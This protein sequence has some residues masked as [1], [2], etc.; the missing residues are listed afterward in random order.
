MVDSRVAGLLN[1]YTTSYGDGGKLFARQTRHMATLGACHELADKAR[2]DTYI[3][4]HTRMTKCL[5]ALLLSS[6]LVVVGC[7]ETEEMSTEE[8]ENPV[9][10]QPSVDEINKQIY[11]SG[12]MTDKQATI[13]SKRQYLAVNGLASITDEQA[14]I[15]SNVQSL[16]LNGLA[17]ITDA[18]AESLSKVESLDLD[19]LTSITDAQ[20][21]SLGVTAF[22]LNGLTSISDAQAE[23]LS[24]RVDVGLFNGLTSISD[25]QAASLSK[26]YG[27][28]LNGLTT[29]TDAQAES[30]GNVQ[31]LYLDGLTSITDAQAASLSK[32]K[33]L[34]LNGLTSITDAQAESLT[35]PKNLFISEDLQP[36]IDK[37]RNE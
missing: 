16:E 18:Q 28:R 11:S 17:T 36:L 37:F 22:S 23:S 7:G 21:E 1:A 32:V 20:A 30:L 3:R 12:T 2:S 6:C 33:V 34:H 9:K 5:V 8:L 14:E 27:L 13:L 19:G 10:Q 15:L 24:L 35:K 25:A 31:L 29:I 4:K 26:G